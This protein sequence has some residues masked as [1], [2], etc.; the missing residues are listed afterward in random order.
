MP[1]DGNHVKAACFFGHLRER[2]HVPHSMPKS[3]QRGRRAGLFL[4]AAKAGAGADPRA[5][6]GLPPPP[7][8]LP[9]RP[10]TPARPPPPSA[11]PA[12]SVSP[13][14]ALP[15]SSFFC[16]SSSSMASAEGGGAAGG[17][18]GRKQRSV[19]AVA[20]RRALRPGEQA[21]RGPT[22]SGAASALTGGSPRATRPAPSPPPPSW[23]PRKHTA[24]GG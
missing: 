21:R 9:R 11:G 13:T 7:T 3:G 24:G 18:W 22:R 8:R 23:S 5:Y 17:A 2:S 14:L 16:R 19:Q 6:P 4:L 1:A 15:A 12:A 20:G 10:P